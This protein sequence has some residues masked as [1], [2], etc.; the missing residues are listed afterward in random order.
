[1]LELSK[2]YAMRIRGA[3]AERIHGL[4]TCRLRRA[5]SKTRVR[6]AVST[7]RRKIDASANRQA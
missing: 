6:R 5:D 2:F 7:G 4:G 3:L 1:M